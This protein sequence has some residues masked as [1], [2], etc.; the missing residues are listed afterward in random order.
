MRLRFL[1]A[2]ES[3]GR[4]L[5]GVLE[6]MPAGLAL[7]AGF[8]QRELS[9]RKYGLGR[10]SRQKLEPDRVEILCG[11]RRGRTLGSPIALMVLN[12]DQENALWTPLT[13]PR[14]GHADLAMERGPAP[15]VSLI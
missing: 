7:A 11:V 2:G 13:V 5:V 1:S 9:R 8:I 10:S 12:S 3:H 15:G 6:G 14:P 4:A